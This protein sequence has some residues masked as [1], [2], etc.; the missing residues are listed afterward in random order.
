MHPC[1]LDQL[2]VWC[3]GRQF[4]D[5]GEG[6][7]VA[8]EGDVGGP[9]VRLVEDVRGVDDGGTA[10]LT[11][12]AE[13]VHEALAGEYVEL[14]CELVDEAQPEWTEEFEHDTHLLPLPVGNTVHSPVEVDAQHAHKL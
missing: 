13:V 12:G 10:L 9:V 3:E 4:M 7:V 14:D 6:L 2:L 8:H 11:L 1:P 5:R